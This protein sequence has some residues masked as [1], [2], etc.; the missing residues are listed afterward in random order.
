MAIEKYSSIDASHIRDIQMNLE[1]MQKEISRSRGELDRE[2]ALYSIPSFDSSSRLILFTSTSPQVTTTQSLQIELDK[3]ADDFRH[4]QKRRQEII[5][6]YEALINSIRDRDALI[7]KNRNFF[8]DQQ[9]TI[10]RLSASVADH[11]TILEQREA[12]NVALEAQVRAIDHRLQRLLG[13]FQ[14]V[15][16]QLQLAVDEVSVQRGI[17][18]KVQ[19]ELHQTRAGIGQLY[20]QAEEKEQQLKRQAEKLEVKKKELADVTDETK[21]MEERSFQVCIRRHVPPSIS[22]SLFFICCVASSSPPFR[23]K[24]PWLRKSSAAL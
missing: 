11:K 9:A 17:N 19:S 6:Q 24:L 7:D 14:G 5:E 3:T 4:I 21:S 20:V 2:V 8:R 13:D 23:S 15:G 16:E 10:A 18:E 12:Q 22:S 1:R